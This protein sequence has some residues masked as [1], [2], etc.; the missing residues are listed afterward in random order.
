[1]KIA[2]H[3][4]GIRRGVPKKGT[5]RSVHW[6]GGVGG[7]GRVGWG[8][9]SQSPFLRE[10]MKVAAHREGFGGGVPKKGD[11]P[12]CPLEW[13]CRRREGVWVGDRVVSPLF[14]RKHEDRRSSR[15]IR[16]GAFQK[17]GQTALSTGVVVSAVLRACGLRDRVVSPLFCVGAPRRGVSGSLM[18]PDSPLK[19]RRAST[20]ND[21]PASIAQQARAHVLAAQALFAERS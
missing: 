5:D 2:A 18:V 13:W 9:S 6:S 14:A 21:R 3:R 1:M 17:R 4:T 12:L 11:R 20:I 16:R 19:N 10:S 8:Q 7:C 15:G